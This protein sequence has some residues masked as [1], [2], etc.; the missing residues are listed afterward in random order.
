[1]ATRRKEPPQP[2]N[3]KDKTQKGKVSFVTTLDLSL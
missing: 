2:R 3:Q 1:M